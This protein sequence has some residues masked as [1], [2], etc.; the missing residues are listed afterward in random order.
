MNKK[1]KRP[2]NLTVLES[3]GFSVTDAMNRRQAAEKR[4]LEAKK[5]LAKRIDIAVGNVTKNGETFMKFGAL[6]H[7]GNKYKREIYYNPVLN[8]AVIYTTEDV[9]VLMMDLVAKDLEN[10]GYQMQCNTFTL[11]PPESGLDFV[12]YQR[13]ELQPILTRWDEAV[14]DMRKTNV[15]AYESLLGKLKEMMFAGFQVEI[16]YGWIS[17][18]DKNKYM[19]V[20]AARTSPYIYVHNAEGRGIAIKQ[21][22]CIF[23]QLFENL[24]D[25][26]VKIIPRRGSIDLF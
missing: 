23:E 21:G 9:A 24:R 15:L 5:S 16:Q 10:I 3:L 18:E 13:Y 11:L 20:T 26:P 25:T 7:V 8:K 4:V 19:F 6:Y 12:A 22:G 17:D 1:E 2:A 14:V